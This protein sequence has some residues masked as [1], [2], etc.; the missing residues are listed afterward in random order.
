MSSK[1]LNSGFSINFGVIQGGHGHT[2]QTW[3]GNPGIG[4]LGQ[5][6]T[7]TNEYLRSSLLEKFQHP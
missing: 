6:F 2:T 1:G 7:K 3:C 5:S 4:D